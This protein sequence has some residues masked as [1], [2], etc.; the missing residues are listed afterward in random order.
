MNISILALLIFKEIPSITTIIGGVKFINFGYTYL[1][2]SAQASKKSYKGYYITAIVIV[3]IVILFV[4]IIPITYEKTIPRSVILI[5]DKPT[6]PARYYYYYPVYIDVSG[7]SG[8]VVSG[9]VVETAGYDIRFYVFDQK[10]FNAWK[11]GYSS[12]PYVDSGRITSY[13]FSL[14][15]DHSDYYYFVLDNSY[16]WFTNKVP[17]ITATWNYQETV[18]EYR[19]VSL[20]QLLTGTY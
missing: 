14:V 5:N 13:S 10:G 17:Q 3:I 9:S 8:N 11:N 20:F 1:V 19:T 4:P 16:S 6:V 7:K 18:T 12:Q 2:M 15:P